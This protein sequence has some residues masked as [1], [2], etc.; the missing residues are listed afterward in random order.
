M[1]SQP[2]NGPR[3]I[4]V[5]TYAYDA[6]P[7]SAV[8]DGRRPSASTDGGAGKSPT[9]MTAKLRPIQIIEGRAQDLSIPRVKYTRETTLK[10]K[11]H[12]LRDSLLRDLAEEVAR[13]SRFLSIADYCRTRTAPAPVTC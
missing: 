10:E 9:L 13:C 5:E 11:P 3:L 7:L 4:D 1:L 8:D 6:Y 12:F 2:L